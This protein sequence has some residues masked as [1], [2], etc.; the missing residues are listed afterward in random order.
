MLSVRWYFYG[1]VNEERRKT[2]K[3]TRNGGVVWDLGL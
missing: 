1:G 2:V 3:K